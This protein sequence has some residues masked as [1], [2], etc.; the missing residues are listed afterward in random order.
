M[1]LAKRMVSSWIGK[2]HGVFLD[3]LRSALDI[4]NPFPLRGVIVVHR[5]SPAKDEVADEK[6]RNHV[7]ENGEESDLRKNQYEVE[8]SG[9]IRLD[10]LLRLDDL[11]IVAFLRRR[12]TERVLHQVEEGTAP[13]VDGDRYLHRKISG[14]QD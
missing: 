7:N 12:A 8:H 6:P 9:G 14:K 5:R 13:V 1:M 10:G 3:T 4:T 11:D 2:A